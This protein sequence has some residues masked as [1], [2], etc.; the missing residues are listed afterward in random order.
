MGHIKVDLEM[1]P[2]TGDGY[3]YAKF[4]DPDKA[5]E[6]LLGML[7]HDGLLTGSENFQ[8]LTE[9]TLERFESSPREWDSFDFYGLSLSSGQDNG[10]KI[11]QTGH[12]KRLP[13]LEKEV[14][15]ATFRSIRAALAWISHTRPDIACLV[16]RAAQVTD[17]TL[18]PAEVKMVNDCIKTLKNEPRLGLRFSPLDVNTL[19]CI[20]LYLR[21]Y[22]DA[23]FGNNHD[24]TSQIGFIILLCN[25]KGNVGTVV[26]VNGTARIGGA[27]R[28][29]TPA[30]VSGDQ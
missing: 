3:P 28:C 4:E 23:S 5:A 29:E 1:E 27:G 9:K 25:S 18:S 8:R 20:I 16:N 15:C 10:I 17:A 21:V 7:V 24:C 13:L 12:I 14:S 19:M 30:R 6:G 26:R 11:C 22:T 2:M